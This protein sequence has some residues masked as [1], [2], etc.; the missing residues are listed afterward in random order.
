MTAPDEQTLE[1][2]CEAGHVQELRLRGYTREGAEHLGKIMDGTH[3]M[4]KH[5]PRADPQPGGVVGRCSWPVQGAAC[6]RFFTA[7][8]TG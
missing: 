7:T 5:P 4:Y 1:L 8:V 3:P 6:G 2:R